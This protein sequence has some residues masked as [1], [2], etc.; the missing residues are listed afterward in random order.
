MEYMIFP[1]VLGLAERGWAPNPQ[2]AT[3]PDTAKSNAM[4]QQAWSNFVNI[5]GKRELP[6]L[7]YI[8]G[9]YD[10]RVP[11]PGVILQD[12][13]YIANMQF[14]GFVIRYTIDGKDPD[15]KSK[16]YN[17]AVT[18]TGANVKF[19]AFDTK[20]RGSNVSETATAKQ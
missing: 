16:I 8:N 12:G 2:W 14:P 20:G 4:Y 15:N 13:K 6:R 11:K 9:G 19:R 1:S 5:M 7:S 17:D 10:Y 3:E 18:I